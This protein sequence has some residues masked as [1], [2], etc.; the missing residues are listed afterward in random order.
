MIKTINLQRPAV[1]TAVLLIL[2][3][4]S[5]FCR[6][7]ET[8][9]ENEVPI[10][11][12]TMDGETTDAF[13]GE[14]LVPENR[15]NP[16]SRMIPIRYVRF[17][18]TTTQPGPPI[19]YLA[20]GPGGSGIKTAKY[21]GFRFPLFMALREHGDVIA[22]DQ[23][24]TGASSKLPDC[25]SETVVPVS[26]VLTDVEITQY[27]RAAADE[28]VVF[29]Q[30]Q[31]IDIA[32]Y[33]TLENAQ[34]IDDVREH[35]GAT[36][37]TLWGISY[38]SHLALASL[39]VMEDRVHKIVI[40]SAEGLGQTVKL[41]SRTDAYFERLQVA[42]NTQPDAA[43]LYPDVHAL[44]RRVHKSL[45]ERPIRLQVPDES[46]KTTELL[47]QR[48]HMQ[49]LASG[50]IADPHRGVVQLLALYRG[51]DLAGS[52]DEVKA[53]L[54]GIAKR[55]GFAEPNVSFRLMPL[56][57][58][59][60]SGISAKRLKVV[61]MEAKSSLLGQALSFPMPQ[62]AE[63][64]PGLDLGDEFRDFPES[65]VPTLLLTGTLDGRTYIEGQ[66]EATQG[67][68]NLT[69]VMVT[70]AGHNLFMVSPDVTT[71]IHSFLSDKPIGRTEIVIPLPP[72]VK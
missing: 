12:E 30:A 50:M 49:V 18:A 31:G 24:G 33:N 15:S 65:K 21:P 47:F 3:S 59:V 9:V 27:Y 45:D 35:L 19:I 43:S 25:E 70:N 44:I 42:I 22:L 4:S 60:A 68:S 55:A 38:G 57:M 11:F 58:D 37:V 26:E 10:V 48:F 72:F 34:D 20:G 52:S 54:V 63:Q 53:T 51:L 66:R 14:L 28:C 40:A 13:Q 16:K 61:E 41:P 17:P 29:W 1:L 6:A 71:A 67:L 64:I 36:H 39:K 23:R 32:G 62:L 7:G 46:G 56:A 69:H 8:S 2:I 5:L